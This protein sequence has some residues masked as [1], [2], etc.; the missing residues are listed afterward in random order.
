MDPVTLTTSIVTLIGAADAVILSLRKLASLRHMSA[1]ICVL[2]N[3]VSDLRL[4]LQEVDSLL[5][6]R[7]KLNGHGTKICRQPDPGLQSLVACLKPAKENL[8]ALE[9]LI[10]DRFLRVD[11]SLDRVSF[12]R[13]ENKAIRL[14]NDIHYSRIS[15]GAAVAV[16]TSCVISQT[17]C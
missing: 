6:E 1:T 13:L 14:Q 12:L 15:I 16:L 7:G 2:N 5:L 3:E 10:T 9:S 17:P 8:L 11:K 4:L